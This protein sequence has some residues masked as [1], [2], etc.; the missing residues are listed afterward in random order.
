MLIDH[1]R[2]PRRSARAY[3]SPVDP[4]EQRPSSPVRELMIASGILRPCRGAPVLRRTFHNLANAPV[5]PC[6]RTGFA[7]AAR[8]LFEFERH[9]VPLIVAQEATHP[10]V[11]SD[12]LARLASSERGA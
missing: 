7:V 10:Q 3:A 2:T 6:D 9:L 12:L 8:D 1:Q 11:R 4:A 5:Y